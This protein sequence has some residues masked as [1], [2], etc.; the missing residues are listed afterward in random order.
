MP[1]PTVQLA[2]DLAKLIGETKTE[3]V[4]K[5]LRDRLERIICRRTIP[6]DDYL[7]APYGTAA[8]ASNTVVKLDQNA[9]RV[10]DEDT[11]NLSL[12]VREGFQRRRELDAFGL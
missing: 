7:F 1:N 4:T 6:R 9:V 10:V 12:R 5:V 3:A 11:P 8:L 2:A